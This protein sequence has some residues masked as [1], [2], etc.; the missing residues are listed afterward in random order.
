MKTCSYCVIIEIL[1]SS[2]PPNQSFLSDDHLEVIINNRIKSYSTEAWQL[3]FGVFRPNLVNVP[4]SVRE[5]LS[6]GHPIIVVMDSMDNKRDREV[7]MVRAYLRQEW[8]RKEKQRFRGETP[9]FSAAGI[10]SLYP[11]YLPQQP[12]GCDCGVYTLVYAERSLQRWKAN[13]QGHDK[14]TI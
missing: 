11:P 12:N 8:E 4:A 5:K 6:L 2:S 9:D 13:I 1:T 14:R 3:Y 10:Q 7:D